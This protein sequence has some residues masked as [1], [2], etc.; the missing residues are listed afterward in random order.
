MN[1]QEYSMVQTLFLKV[2]SSTLYS[3]VKCTEE[4][5][6]TERRDDGI[7]VAQL[8]VD[9]ESEDTHHGS[10]SVVELDGTLLELGFFVLLK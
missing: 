10:T 5:L 2:N 8:F 4:H 9:H 7:E 3:K 1:K 6:T